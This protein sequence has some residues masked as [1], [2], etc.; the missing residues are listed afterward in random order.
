MIKQLTSTPT[1]GLYSAHWLGWSLAL[2]STVAQSIV[3]P[4]ARSVI[5]GGLSPTLLLLI[6]LSLA[7]LLLAITLA[8]LI[9]SGSPSTGGVWDWWGSLE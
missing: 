5:I 8:L 6:R 1:D 2:G 9:A 7:V 3:T 4:L